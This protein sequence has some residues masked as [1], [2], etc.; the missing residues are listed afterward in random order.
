M[1]A[2]LFKCAS[3]SQVQMTFTTRG[4]R[5]SDLLGELAEITKNL[6]EALARSAQLLAL[7]TPDTFL[8]RRTFEP[9]PNE[10]DQPWLF[11]VGDDTDWPT[12]HSF[13]S[14]SAISGDA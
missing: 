6:N 13:G 5:R 9:F 11:G 8:G 3:C 7:S 2:H 14:Q 10:S 4:S 1:I 12:R